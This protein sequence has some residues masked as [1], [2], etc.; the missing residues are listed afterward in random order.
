MPDSSLMLELYELLS[1]NVNELLMGE[2]VLEN[3][4]QKINLRD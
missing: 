1:I 4:K 2:R 3:N